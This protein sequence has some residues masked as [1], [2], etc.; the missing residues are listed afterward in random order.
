MPK[1]VRPVS[2]EQEELLRELIAAGLLI[3]S[4]VPGVYGHSE[5]FEGVRD[6]LDRRLTREARVRGAIKLRFPPVLPRRHLEST[7][8]LGNFPHLAG[9]IFSFDGTEEE[10]AEQ[11]T[12]AADHGDWS[13]FQ[14]QTEVTLM[15]AACYPV[16]PAVAQRGRLEPGGLFV[17]AGASWVF[18]HEPS[19][20]PARRQIFHQHE[21]VRLGEPEIV[22]DWRGRVVRSSGSSCCGAS[23]STPA[24]TGRT[25]RSSAGAGG[26]SRRTSGPRI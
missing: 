22:L 19:L 7:G 15:P 25:T 4:G 23:A 9:S 5:T 3:D 24:S 14:S 2:P 13:E 11:A 18:R 1:E 20:D 16:Y 17:D 10:A 21:L 8:Y 6:A 26:C 12:R